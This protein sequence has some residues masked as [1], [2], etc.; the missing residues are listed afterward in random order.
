MAYAVRLEQFEGPLDLLLSLIRQGE[1]DIYDIPIARITEQYLDALELMAALD[2]EVS[3]EFIVL[4]AA[5]IQIKLR[6]LLPRPPG[7][8]EESEPDDPRRQ[9]VEQLIEYKRY[10]EAARHLAGR[11]SEGR[12][13]FSRAGA[14]LPDDGDE[15]HPT[16]GLFDL[17]LAFKELLD[18]QGRGLGY[19]I[20]GEDVTLDDR[21]EFVQ[22]ALSDGGRVKF[23]DLF[24]RAVRRVVIVVTFLAVLELLRR[25]R[26]SLHQ[27]QL[28]GEIWIEH[29][30]RSS[31]Q[32]V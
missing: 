16:G 25:G 26:I 5:L 28:F 18:R 24:P 6:M 27:D 9:L 29:N 7:A 1:I 4:A 23:V 22:R 20:E 3:G 19:E 31:P 12:C 8:E 15:P 13:V 14:V 30:N 21:L 32:G 17:L 2:L 11:E 10:K